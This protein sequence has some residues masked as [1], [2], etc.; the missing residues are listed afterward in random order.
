MI[1]AKASR[2]VSDFIQFTHEADDESALQLLADKLY[3]IKSDMEKMALSLGERGSLIMF[4][5]EQFG[6]LADVV[7]R[8]VE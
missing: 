6:K 7:M 2:A 8:Y 1:C 4:L 5:G 3:A